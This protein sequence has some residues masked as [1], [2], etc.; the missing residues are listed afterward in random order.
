M[1]LD[2]WMILLLTEH[3]CTFFIGLPAA[4]WVIKHMLLKDFPTLAIMAVKPSKPSGSWIS[5]LLR[6]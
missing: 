1:N 4:Y 3:L 5:K 2:Q 6:K